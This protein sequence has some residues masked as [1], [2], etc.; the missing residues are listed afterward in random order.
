MLELISEGWLFKQSRL[1]L[2][3]ATMSRVQTAEH[4]CVCVCVCVH[5]QDEPRAKRVKRRVQRAFG[6]GKKLQKKAG[7]LMFKGMPG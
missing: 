1:W 2:R 7:Q 4:M 5:T 3:R 6:M